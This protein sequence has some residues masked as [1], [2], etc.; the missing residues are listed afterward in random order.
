MKKRKLSMNF[1]LKCNLTALERKIRFCESCEFES[2]WGFYIFLP[3]QFF[4][5]Y[6]WTNTVKLEKF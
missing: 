2:R 1:F 6:F 5:R 3:F 4:K